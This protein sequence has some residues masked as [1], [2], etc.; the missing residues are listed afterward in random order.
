MA[1]LEE[2]DHE[3]YAANHHDVVKVFGNSREALY[4]HYKRHGFHEGRAH[5]AV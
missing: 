3:Y 4:G 5:K 2:F 1:T